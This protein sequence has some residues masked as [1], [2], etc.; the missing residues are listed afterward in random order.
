[1]KWQCLFLLLFLAPTLVF[2]LDQDKCTK[3]H[4][5]VA[6]EWK[7]HY[8]LVAEHN[9]LNTNEIDRRWQLLKES[10]ECSRRA[11]THCD[12]ILNDI[13][14]KSKDKRKQPWRIQMKKVC[15]EDKNRLNAEI[16]AI[17]PVI[18]ELEGHLASQKAGG[19]YQ[20][21][22]E[23]AI[24]AT[25][26]E[27]ACQRRL[28]NIDEVVAVLN[29]VSQLYAEATSIARE[30]LALV[31]PHPSRLQDQKDLQQ[32]IEN[33]QEL[34]EK[35]KKESANWPA[36]AATQKATL[37][38]KVV[39]LK[40]D[41]KLFTEKGL[42]RSCYEL[43]KQAVPLLE[44][45]I[46]SSTGKEL[47]FF[48]EEIALLRADISAFEKEADSSRLTDS[49][50]LL[51]PEEFKAR[52]K[53]RKDLFFKSDFLL[54]TDLFF[55]EN[56]KNTPFPRVVP[57]D[58]QKGKRKGDFTLY[59]EQF[60]RFLVQSESAVP[61]LFIKVHENGQVIHVE[62]ISLPFE[63]TQG[64]E[65]YLKNGMLF[66]PETKLKSEFGLD[67][68]LSF[69]CDPVNKFSMIVTQKSIDTRYQ[70]SVS[71]TLETALYECSF[72]AP[73]PWQL[74]S[75]RKPAL[76]TPN[77]P[78][79]QSPLPSRGVT[80][81]DNSGHIHLIEPYRFPVLDKLVEELKNDPFAL[82]SY[83][84]NEIAFVDPY[85][86]QE[87]GVFHAPN[88][89]RN[90]CMTYLEKQGSA[91]EQCQLLVYLLRKAGYLA[92]YAIGAPSSLPK[93]FVE[94]MLFTKLPEDQSEALL[95]YPWVVFLDGKEWVSLF[96]WMK[97][98][99]IQEGHDLYSYMPEDYASANRWILHYLKGDEKI[100]KHIGPD[101]D[102]TAG[103][104]FVRFV[105]EELRKQGLSL[106]D[107][108]IHRTQIKK[109]FL[110]WQDFPHPSIPDQAQILTFLH[111]DS[112]LFAKVKI[113]LCSHQ[114]PQK[115][116]SRV[117]TLARL[118]TGPSFISF[119]SHEKKHQLHLQIAGENI[120]PPLELDES[121]HLVDVK[122]DYEV[123]LGSQVFR[124]K[125][126]F[127]VAKGTTAAL[128]SHFGG[129]SPKM[130]SQ[131]YEQFSVEKEE[132][133]RL[134]ALLSFVGS[135]YFE[136]CSRTEKIL[137]SLH[138]VNPT[139]VF[140][141]GLSKL[142]PDLSKGTFRGD[143]DLSMPQ[144]DMFW[145]HAG[146]PTITHPSVWHQ[147]FYTARM[148]CESLITVDSSSNEH[149]ILREVF[150]DPYAV[151]TVKL[152]QLAHQQQQRNGLEGEGFLSFTATSFE[153]A[154][155]TPE[156]AQSL[157]FSHLKDLN[158]RDVKAA[159]P[160]QWNV[161]KDLLDPNHPW[162]SWSYAYMTP[163]LTFIQDGSYK[164]MGALILCPYTQYA[165]ISSNNLLFHGGLGSPLPSSY[166]TPHA[167]RE[168]QLVPTA[169][170]YTNSYTLHLPSP[171]TPFSTYTYPEVIQSLPG[172]KEWTSDV[173]PWYKAAWNSIADPIDTVTG[174][175]YID[176]TDLVLPGLFSLTI[177]RNYNSQNPL[178]ADLGCG[179]KLSLNPSLID[180]DGKR[181][182]AELDGTVI[183]YRHNRQTG[184]WEVS[185]EDNPE[186][187]NFNQQGIGS[188]ASPFHSYIENDVLYGADG[189]KRF[190]ED[191]LLQ[192]WVDARGNVLSF[193]YQ[194]EHLARIESSN[195]DFCGIHYNH[196]ENISEIYAKD[197]RRISY[198]YD[199]QGDLIKV[200]LPNTA[201]ISYE[202]DRNHRLTGRS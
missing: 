189:S 12:T 6:S 168:W 198:D 17:Q 34:S 126:T 84:Q 176:E 138:K 124:P 18:Q 152:L 125:Q 96:P 35:Y 154:D 158:L 177:R 174:A 133:K 59:T 178:I 136:K 197:G 114:N 173:R 119:S 89:H 68:R 145:F 85:L 121:D 153:A 26:K 117:I 13:A 135:S 113:E 31:A 182:A 115:S 105:E 139:I 184:R 167:I 148:Q 200:T 47:E 69:A 175:F 98:I 57:L 4:N 82:A 87:N 94:R 74:E 81:H 8:E 116:I 65:T 134:P 63:N 187:S 58:G 102:D 54:T 130:T 194:N 155:K 43:Q 30:A 118:S 9:K 99:Q 41:G 108:G 2:G 7:R 45:L 123:I 137:A 60:Y 163:G 111:E 27:R 46:E 142:S 75:L 91:W 166:F 170:S 159:C 76:V 181:F 22:L 90:P 179:W 83:V 33:Y 71:L 62:K 186:L 171:F 73:P 156:A 39:T 51:S 11:I 144:V 147:E 127:S 183:V 129:A 86:H 180:Q 100:L 107:I 149:Q 56:L 67:L 19:V 141:F 188:S 14:S 201:Q 190:Y 48:K 97:E 78:I 25:T 110:S 104:L 44:K 3:I 88:I 106:N 101:G 20:R 23:K 5:Q 29:E 66:T 49:T 72:S 146:L 42:K 38:E 64:W 191:G 15:E 28:N 150:K 169:S 165:L 199:S 131:F 50:P 122:I 112:P 195:G 202:Y 1:M 10:V 132:K 21:S 93:D 157:Y 37:K 32:V 185:P 143:E 36:F 16:N 80:F 53:E 24:Q 128:C 162:S 164:E 172:T 55:S 79:D 161:L 192:K 160:G 52:E 70:F 103:V 95:Q 151:S 109:Q 61:E 193:S 140:A 77:Q 196:E 120:L 40:E 92:V